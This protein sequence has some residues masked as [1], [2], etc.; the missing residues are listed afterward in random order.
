MNKEEIDYIEWAK[1]CGDLIKLKP[2]VK[3][4]WKSATFKKCYKD[5]L[6][7]NEAVGLA[8]LACN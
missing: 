8:W 7:S 1:Q 3:I 5:G 4:R 2:H 6:T